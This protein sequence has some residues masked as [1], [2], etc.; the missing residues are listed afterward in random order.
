MVIKGE[1]KM[2]NNF[3]DI[4]SMIYADKII[5]ATE[6]SGFSFNKMSEKSN[7]IQALLKR[8][9]SAI[10]DKEIGMTKKPGKLEVG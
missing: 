5:L 3:Y 10:M 8:Y 6:E 4:M 9:K 7:R 2:S 1:D